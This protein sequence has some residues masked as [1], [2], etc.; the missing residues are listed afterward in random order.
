MSYSFTTKADDKFKLKAAVSDE[1]DKVVAQQPVHA[2]D[3]GVH[4]QAA[5]AMIDLVREPRE[6]EEIVAS[7]NGS[8]WKDDG[9]DK[10]NGG[11]ISVNISHH[12]K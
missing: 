3:R 9:A 12:A 7:I 4:Q 8:C 10:L 5:Y 11:S 1:L 6:S 2:A